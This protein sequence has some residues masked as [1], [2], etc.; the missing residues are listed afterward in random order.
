MFLRTQQQVLYVHIRALRNKSITCC[1]HKTILYRTVH[2]RPSTAAINNRRIFTLS[3]PKNTL[4]IRARRTSCE[5]TLFCVNND[6]SLSRVLAKCMPFRAKLWRV[7]RCKCKLRLVREGIFVY[8]DVVL[9]ASQHGDTRVYS[10][11]RPAKNLAFFWSER[12]GIRY[13]PQTCD[14][15]IRSSSYW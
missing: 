1:H 12:A 6:I 8:E 3:P 2:P 4:V 7:A 11:A 5:C 15:E 13:H 9:R 10:L 14:L